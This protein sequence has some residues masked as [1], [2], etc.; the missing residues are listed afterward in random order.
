MEKVVVWVHIPKTGGKSLFKMLKQKYKV[1]QIYETIGGWAYSDDVNEIDD[2]IQDYYNSKSLTDC[3]QYAKDHGYNAIIGN[4]VA[5]EIKSVCDSIYGSSELYCFLRE[6]IRRTVSEYQHNFYYGFAE[7]SFEDFCKR[8]YN[9]QW[10]Q[11][12]GDLSLFTFVGNFATFKEQI[13]Q[14]G[15]NEE[16]ENSSSSRDKVPVDPDVAIPYNKLDI[17]LFKNAFQ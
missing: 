2:K 1:L 7:P 5:R 3:V 8:T 4:L 9:T 16:H 6:P 14:L 15:F 13:L 17:E 11:T 12:S 10:R